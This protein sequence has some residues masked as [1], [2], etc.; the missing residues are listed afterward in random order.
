MIRHRSPSSLLSVV[1]LVGG[2]AFASEC[3]GIEPDT[4]V[5]PSAND[6]EAQ[7][8][9]EAEGLPRFVAEALKKIDLRADQK[10]T[11]MTIQADSRRDLEP[12]RAG[13]KELGLLLADQVKKNA[14]DP[15]L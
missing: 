10:Q 5:A 12:V 7:G 11:I 9:S 14:I 6:T 15:V 1:A 8:T 2:I 3:S 13:R 4:T